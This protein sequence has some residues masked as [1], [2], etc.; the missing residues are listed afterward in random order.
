MDD[1]TKRFIKGMKV[2]RKEWKTWCGK[3]SGQISR[4]LESARNYAAKGRFRQARQTAWKALMAI[5][6]LDRV[7]QG[8]ASNNKILKTLPKFW[9]QLAARIPAPV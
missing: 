6:E 7:W 1:E 3:Q 9:A 2:C 4:I 5:D 8:T